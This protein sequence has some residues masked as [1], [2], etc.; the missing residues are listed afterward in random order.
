MCGPPEWTSPLTEARPNGF[1]GSGHCC[2]D[3]APGE[4][5][6]LCRR[7]QELGLRAA[8]SSGLMAHDGSVLEMAE[9]NVKRLSCLFNS[10]V[11]HYLIS[12]YAIY[13]AA[14]IIGANC[15]AAL[16]Y[17]RSLAAL[18]SCGHYTW[19]LWPCTVLENRAISPHGEPTF[20]FLASISSYVCLPGKGTV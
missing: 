1:Q 12:A 17:C 20:L 4:W 6:L 16:I 5:A 14:V 11:T 9:C 19:P 18:C 13:A 2:V 7:L 3:S 8:P 10:Q 15:S